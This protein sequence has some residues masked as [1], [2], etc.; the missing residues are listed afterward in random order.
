MIQA[1][2]LAPTASHS[3]NVTNLIHMACVS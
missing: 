3:A 2:A 1:T